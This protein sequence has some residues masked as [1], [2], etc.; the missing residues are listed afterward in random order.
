LRSTTL[1]IVAIGTLLPFTP[2][3]ASLGFVPLPGIYLSFVA[4]AT[5]IYLLLVE[6]G[7]R[8]LL[9]PTPVRTT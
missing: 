5:L 7:K 9:R 3:A 1:L 4:A 8:F 6:I 2:V